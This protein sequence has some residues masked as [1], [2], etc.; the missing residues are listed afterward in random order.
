[1]TKIQGGGASE[2]TKNDPSNNRLDKITKR[3]SKVDC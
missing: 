3:K 2:L 1:M